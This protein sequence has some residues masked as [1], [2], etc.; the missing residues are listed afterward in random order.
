MNEVQLNEPADRLRWKGVGEKKTIN[1]IPIKQTEAKFSTLMKK[2]KDLKLM[3]KKI[4][5]ATGISIQGYSKA[6]RIYCQA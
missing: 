6:Q 2:N 4:Y 3:K 5:C 1:P